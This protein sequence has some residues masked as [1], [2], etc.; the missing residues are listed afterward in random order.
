VLTPSLLVLVLPAVLLSAPDWL[1]IRT[2]DGSVVEGQAQLPSLKLATGEVRPAQIASIHNAAPLT[3][4][5]SARVTAA[6]A[7]IAGKDRAARDKAVDELTGI[8]LAAMTPVLKTLRD[9]QQEEPRPLYRLF[10]KL[11]PSYADGFDRTLSV[12]RLS[13]GGGLRG[14]LPAGAFELKLADGSKSSIEWSK[15]RSLAVRQKSVRRAFEIHSLRHCTQVEYL[16]TGLVLTGSSKLDVAARGFVRL[17]WNEDGWASGA[18]GLTKP[19]SS[20]YKSN[21]IDG[22]PF[23]ALVG[24][25]GADGEV[26]FLG[27]KAAKTGLPPGR[28][29]LAVNDNRHW[30]NNIGS[31][32]VDLT[33]ADAYVLG[34]PQ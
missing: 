18:S 21:L 15:V 28:L 32:S 4:I 11:M 12:I 16:D 3:E 24:R 17:S 5:E 14:N 13:S 8:G 1:L 29:G 2:V 7:A 30:Q 27:K 31:F 22:H 25:I 23:G 26:F 10:E 19:G 6:L 20:S 9:T 34:D 33:A